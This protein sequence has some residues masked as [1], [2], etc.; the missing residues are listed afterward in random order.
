[1]PFPYAAA[2][3]DTSYFVYT[4]ALARAHTF[5]TH[6]APPAHIRRTARF[7]ILGRVDGDWYCHCQRLF[8]TLHAV[9]AIPPLYSL[10]SVTHR[11]AYRTHSR[12]T[13]TLR[14]RLE[15]TP[16]PPFI[17]MPPTLIPS[18]MALG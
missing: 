18:G 17:Y 6:A 3:R 14:A 7:T 4:G 8:N 10:Y 16:C 11:G 12:F 1:M 13:H 15:R 9:A 2:L 5:F